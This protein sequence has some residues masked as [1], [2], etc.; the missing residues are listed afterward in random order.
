[1]SDKFATFDRLKILSYQGKEFIHFCVVW[2]KYQKIAS[3][4]NTEDEVNDFVLFPV[5]L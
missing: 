2:V 4:V 1:M 3:W 5:G